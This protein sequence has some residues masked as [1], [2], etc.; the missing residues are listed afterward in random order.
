MEAGEPGRKL[1]FWSRP[2]VLMFCP[3]QEAR[4]LVVGSGPGSS[5]VLRVALVVFFNGLNVGIRG[6]GKSNMTLGVLAPAN[7]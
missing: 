7:R 5:C 6:R 1:F 2:E 3:R 4:E